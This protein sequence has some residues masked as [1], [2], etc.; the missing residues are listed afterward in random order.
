LR[1]RKTFLIF[2]STTARFVNNKQSRISKTPHNNSTPVVI[3]KLVHSFLIVRSNTSL[4][5]SLC[6]HPFAAASS[7][8]QQA[9]SSKQQASSSKQQQQH[10]QQH[11]SSSIAAAA[12]AAATKRSS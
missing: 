11:S 2:F 7:S 1:K 3:R 8:K 5:L 10:Q 6:S 9:S 12:A 4:S